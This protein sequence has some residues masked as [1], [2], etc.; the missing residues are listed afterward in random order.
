[1]Q[2]EFHSLDQVLPEKKY[3]LVHVKVDDVTVGMGR[4]LELKLAKLWSFT[5][6]VGKFWSAEK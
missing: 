5:D 4:Q 2:T 6:K 1:M 3:K